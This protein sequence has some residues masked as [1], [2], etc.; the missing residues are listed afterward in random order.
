MEFRILGPLD[1]R[2]PD[3]PL[4]V[5]GSKP[6]TVLKALLLRHDQAVP[7][8][9]LSEMLWGDAPPSTSTAQLYT[10]VSRL[11]KLLGP[12]VVIVR[13]QPGYLLRLGSAW[14]DYDEFHDLVQRGRELTAA[15]HHADAAAEITRAL[16]LWRGPAPLADVADPF[17]AAELPRLEEE[18]MA[19][20]ETGM[21]LDLALGR[22]QEVIAELTRLVTDHPYRE[23]LHE[24][25][26][27]ALYRSGRQADALAVYDTA[28]RTLRDELGVDPSEELRAAHLSILNQEPLSVPARVR[29]DLDR[30]GSPF[31]D[32]PEPRRP[33]SAWHGVRPAM[34]PHDIADFTGRAGDLD[35]LLSLV[36]GSAPL[37]QPDTRPDTDGVPSA[38]WDVEPAGAPGGGAAGV[39]TVI[40]GMPGVGKTALAVR[41][42]HLLAGDFPDGQ[43]YV[44]LRGAEGRRLDPAEVLAWFLRALGGDI[45]L[46]S[47][48][49]ERR[50]LYRSR[51]TD[52]RVLV[53]L[54]NA[55]DVRQVRPLLPGGGRCGVIV[56]SGQPLGAIEGSAHLPL[57]PLDLADGLA[58]V[59]TVAGRPGCA[60]DE[61]EAARRLVELCGGLPIAL[62]VACARGASRPHWRLARLVA[63]LEDEQDRLDELQLGDLDVRASLRFSYEGLRDV[64]RRAFRALGSLGV[65]SFPG[66]AVGAVLGLP[67]ARAARIAERLV[68][69]RLLDTVAA[70]PEP[71]FDRYRFHDLV[72]LFAREVAAEEDPPA[73]RDTVLDRAFA[74]WLSLAVAGDR[75]LPSQCFGVLRA[76]VPF[77]VA[78][79]DLRDTLVAEPFSW[80]DAELSTLVALIHQACRTGRTTAAWQLAQALTNYFDMRHRFDEWTSTHEALLAAGRE[81]GDR[82]AEAV[83]HRGLTELAAFFK[84]ADAHHGHAE[85]ARALFAGLGERVGEVD[86]LVH[87]ADG[88]RQAGEHERAVAALTAALD[89]ARRIGHR[90]GEAQCLAGLGEIR[91]ELGEPESAAE[92]FR[93][94]EVIW[95]AL[96]RP[97]YATL[98]LRNI[99]IIERDTGRF[100]EAAAHLEECRS[101]LTVLG[102]RIGVA[103]ALN[104]L[105]DLYRLWDQPERARSL[106]RQA[107]GQ[108][109]ELGLAGGFGH[110]VALRG[111]GEVLLSQG[112][113]A[114]A[115][116]LL[117]HAVQIWRALAMPLWEART[118]LA[119]GD[120][121]DASGARGN[122]EGSWREA[123]ARCA[124]HGY[125]EESEARSRL[126]PV[127]GL[128]PDQ[129]APWNAPS[130]GASGGAVCS[131]FPMVSGHAD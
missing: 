97:R 131:C 106:Y 130:T 102:D 19:A 87:C 32:E 62:R 50:Q 26:M 6:R 56:T 23:K 5:K 89:T 79:P 124:D 37:P 15:G 112:D 28:R 21:S 128:A 118:L 91:L 83:A 63:S 64:D 33:V 98:M 40:S 74:A 111:L 69:A 95:T 96:G 13:Q 25:L 10:Y 9:T 42:A 57:A 101:R 127:S 78:C 31:P 51:L 35:R 8:Q 47:T 30:P 11:R 38:R 14:L 2:S 46:P 120:A 125:P 43:L 104:S 16:A 59:A 114:A 93:G 73:E 82:L 24:Q 4:A 115:V 39:V 72:R 71:L 45:V 119:L 108:F 49:E 121:Q 7:Y 55:A 75:R 94:G 27:T 54:D 68:D 70:G 53:V 105:G 20:V 107:I 3:R 100:A 77:P 1:I 92:L 17:V 116:V 12:D 103:Y 67:Q 29:A 34:L 41:A 84:D 58:F 129:A 48:L 44:D 80:F 113:P 86:A 85:A 66:W 22:H 18:Y 126:D 61:P 117:E 52:R 81:H 123:L 60:A 90:V 36:R 65:P 122:A 88:Y 110:A 109:T 99:G 76:E